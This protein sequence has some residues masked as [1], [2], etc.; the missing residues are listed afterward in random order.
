MRIVAALLRQLRQ[1]AA[2]FSS[3]GTTLAYL[4][5]VFSYRRTRLIGIHPDFTMDRVGS[6]GAG[7][8]G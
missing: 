2:A 8:R 3:F 6:R 5:G 1:C 7:S 4:R